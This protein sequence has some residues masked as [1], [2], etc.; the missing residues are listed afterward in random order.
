M[1]EWASR[2]VPAVDLKA[3]LDEF[4]DYWHGVPGAKGRKLDWPATFRNRLR[5]LKARTARFKEK[6]VE[7]SKPQARPLTLADIERMKDNS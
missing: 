4:V 1:R 6:K 3:A 7:P 2:E 5:E